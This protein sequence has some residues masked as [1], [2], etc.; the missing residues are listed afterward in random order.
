MKFKYWTPERIAS[1]TGSVTLLEYLF[2]LEH[3]GRLRYKGLVGSHHY[4]LSEGVKMAV[5][6]SNYYDFRKSKGGGI[7]GAVMDFENLSFTEALHFLSEFSGLHPDLMAYVGQIEERAIRAKAHY[8]SPEILRIHKIRSEHLAN[9]F[10]FRGISIGVLAAYTMEYHYL[11]RG[12][13]QRA[14][15]IKNVLGGIEL[16]SSSMKVKI[17]PASYSLFEGK[18]KTIVLFEGMT[19]LLS[20]I[21]WKRRG[22]RPLKRTLVCLNSVGMVS[23]FI[24]DYKDFDGNV[25][26]L[27]DGDSA[28]NEATEALIKGLEKANVKDIRLRFGISIS[29][30]NDFNEV[31]LSGDRSM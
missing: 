24:N 4:F 29:G 14:I 21:E 3:Q 13:K 2:H 1:V 20:Y 10:R 6:G 30:R 27:L 16:R 11:L 31:L 26:L 28:G 25:L 15:G 8:K 9:Y 7:I 18:K 22:K 12:R 23:R 17:G 19:D 5:S